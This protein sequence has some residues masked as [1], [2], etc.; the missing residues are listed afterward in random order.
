MEVS[1]LDRPPYATGALFIST[2]S[3]RNLSSEREDRGNTSQHSPGVPTFLP[4]RR[5][6]MYAYTVYLEQFMIGR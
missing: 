2:Y 3:H 4:F 6:Y 5:F 1:R